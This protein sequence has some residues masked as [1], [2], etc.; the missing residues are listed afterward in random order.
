M[1]L[2]MYTERIDC[3]VSFEMTAVYRHTIREL[4]R[5]DK[6]DIQANP[7]EILK[8][9]PRSYVNACWCVGRKA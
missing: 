4:L 3:Q 8:D 2:L 9:G 5:M 6:P 1:L 7:R